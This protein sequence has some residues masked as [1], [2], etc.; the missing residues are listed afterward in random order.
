[1]LLAV[2]HRRVVELLELGDRLA[3]D[4]SLPDASR[5]MGISSEF[6]AKTLAS[7]AR[8][9][10]SDELTAALDGLVEL[11]AMVKGA[12]G[13]ETDEAQRRLAFLLWVRDHVPAGAGR[14]G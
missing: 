5:A 12:P 10:S 2:L 3:G 4:A 6:R 9:W 11:D 14:P 7:Q 1:V 13:F 8:R